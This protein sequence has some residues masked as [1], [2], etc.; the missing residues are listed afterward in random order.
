MAY[1]WITTAPIRLVAPGEV[2][3]IAATLRGQ[4]ASWGQGSEAWDTAKRHHANK[5]G[6]DE[7]LDGLTGEDLN[8]VYEYG[9]L[10]LGLLMVI[11]ASDCIYIANLLAHPGT[12]G[13]GTTLLEFAINLSQNQNTGGKLQLYS[14]N[15]NSTDYYGKMGFVRTAPADPDG[16]GNM[17]LNPA[18][19]ADLWTRQNNGWAFVAFVG[20]NYAG[21]T[22]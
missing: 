22:G 18:S 9:G 20:K 7:L 19:R 12:E 13:C 6:A 4:I 15:Q 3:N 14:M 11:E 16:G 8:Y 17:S 5:T 2:A 10:V 21:A 1:G